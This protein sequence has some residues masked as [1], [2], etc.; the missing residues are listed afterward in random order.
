MVPLRQGADLRDRKGTLTLEGSAIV[1]TERRDG[2]RWEI[3]LA[4]VRRAKRVRGS[5]I[6]LVHHGK[7]LATAFYFAQPPPLSPPPSSPVPR[8]SALSLGG[9]GERRAKRNQIRG[10]A[11]YLSSSSARHKDTIESWVR[12]IREALA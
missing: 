5:P 1:F 7:R 2:T 4:Q 11:V 12:A 8:V 3:P 6:L 9:R 10:N